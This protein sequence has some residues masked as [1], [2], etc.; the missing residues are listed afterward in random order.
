MA[1]TNLMRAVYEI[2]PKN[3]LYVD[4]DS[5]ISKIPMK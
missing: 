1:R 4:T 5:I 3:V 2:G